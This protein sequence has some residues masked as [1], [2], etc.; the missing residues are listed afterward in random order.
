MK[1]ERVCPSCGK[2][3]LPVATRCPRCGYAFETRYDRP[4]GE[5]GPRAGLV[6][7]LAA[8][9]V[10]ALVAANALRSR[11][12]ERGAE[13]H[14]EAALPAPAAPGAVAP[15]STQQRP[16]TPLATQP[17]APSAAVTPAPA[18]AAAPAPSRPVLGQHRYASTWINLR[19]ARSSKATIVRVLRPGEPVRVDSLDQGWYQV[20]TSDQITGYADRR[21][22][23]DAA[24]VARP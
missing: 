24:P 20:V 18:L 2:A 21:L 22:L 8:L 15:E 3:A 9:V 17:P 19:A 10:L 7:A 11:G 4:R 12:P 6:T 1:D 13:V 16:A 23:T 14:R 5:T